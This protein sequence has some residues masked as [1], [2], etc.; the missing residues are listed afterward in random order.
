MSDLMSSLYSQ[1]VSLA[2]YHPARRAGYLINRRGRF[3]GICPGRRY[4]APAG[5]GKKTFARIRPG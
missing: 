5:G 2:L 3:I 1:I 4:L